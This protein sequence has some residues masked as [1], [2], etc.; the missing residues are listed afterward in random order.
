MTVDEVTSLLRCHRI[1]VLRLIRSGALH[2]LMIAH[3]MRFERAEVAAVNNRR[4]AVY[5]HLTLVNR[6]RLAK[7]ALASAVP[8]RS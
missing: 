1:T 7:R 5:P 6:A 2:I 8:I 3:A 4:I